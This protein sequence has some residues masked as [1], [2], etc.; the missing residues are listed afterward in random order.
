MLIHQLHDGLF[1]RT[2]LAPPEFVRDDTNAASLQSCSAIAHVDIGQISGHIVFVDLSN[3][4][5]V[6]SV[7]GDPIA[8]RVLPKRIFCAH[9]TSQFS[10]DEIILVGHEDGTISI[11]CVHNLEIMEVIKAT[12]NG[13]IRSITLARDNMTILAGAEDGH[14]IAIQPYCP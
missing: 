8:K 5:G 12:S 10:G 14:L 6:F 1:L 3:T 11:I 7:N 13:P 4:I 2:L 9:V